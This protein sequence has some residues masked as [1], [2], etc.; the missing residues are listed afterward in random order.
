MKRSKGGV[1]TF[2][3]YVAWY[4]MTIIYGFLNDLNRWCI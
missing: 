1:Y 2:I 4:V 3:K